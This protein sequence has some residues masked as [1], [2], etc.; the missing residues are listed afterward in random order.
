MVGWHH[1]LN[2]HVFEQTQGDSKGQGSLAYCSPWGHKELDTTQ[3]LN[4]NNKKDKV[5][6]HRLGAIAMEPQETPHSL[7]P[8][9]KT[10]IAGPVP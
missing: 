2:G 7:L 6:M 9:G 10:Q 4:N 1:W 3:Q 8:G 5:E